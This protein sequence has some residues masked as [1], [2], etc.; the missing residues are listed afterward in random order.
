MLSG[1]VGVVAFVPL[2]IDISHDADYIVLTIPLPT[3]LLTPA[4][5]VAEKSLNTDCIPQILRK[6][7]TS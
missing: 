6:E 5:K 2:I 7:E 3:A 4:S 1:L